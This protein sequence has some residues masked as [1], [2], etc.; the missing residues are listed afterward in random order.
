MD[1]AA[2]LLRELDRPLRVTRNGTFCR[3]AAALYG[4]KNADLFRQ[5]RACKD[6]S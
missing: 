3:L 5:C 4:N 6:R 1:Q 2:G